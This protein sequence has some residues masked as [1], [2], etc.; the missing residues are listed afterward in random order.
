MGRRR[1]SRV[2]AWL[3]MTNFEIVCFFIDLRASEGGGDL[4]S[5]NCT[6]LSELARPFPPPPIV[7]W[8]AR[9]SLGA[10]LRDRERDGGQSRVGRS[11]EEKH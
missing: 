3:M 9:R 11:S 6:S 2:S 7:R 5:H 8:R 1:E 4:L 10:V